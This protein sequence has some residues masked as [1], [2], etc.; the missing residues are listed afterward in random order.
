MFLDQS[1]NKLN[2]RLTFPIHD[3]DVSDYVTEGFGENVGKY[4]LYSCVCHFGSKFVNLGFE[5]SNMCIKYY[6]YYFLFTFP[7]F[8]RRIG[9]TLHGLCKKPIEQQMALF[10]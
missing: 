1:S 5:K 2:N 7:Y 6:K 10:Q 4:N 8:H 9:W 3:L